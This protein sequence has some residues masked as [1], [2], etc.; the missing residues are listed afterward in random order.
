MTQ[1][2][3]LISGNT[4]SNTSTNDDIFRLVFDKIQTG[5]LIVDANSHII[6][7]ANPVAEEITGLLRDRIIGR[8]CHNF[9]CPALAGQCPIT[10]MHQDFDRTEGGIINASGERVPIL[11]TVAKASVGGKEYLIESFNDI[12]DRKKAEERRVALIAYMDEAVSRVSKPM[13]LTIANLQNIV[14]VAKTGVYDAEDLRMQLQIQTNNIRQMVKNLKEISDKVTNDE[15][16]I[17]DAFK[18][19][20]SGK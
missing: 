11:K 14:D 2:Q 19:Y 20:F 3:G 16:D 1:K 8:T 9:V 15:T 18:D 5:I 6:V 4:N 7:D 17:P 13:E 10:D 12:T